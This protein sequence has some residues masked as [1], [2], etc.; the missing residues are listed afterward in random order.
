[1]FLR[2]DTGTATS[3]YAMVPKI[4]RQRN[5]FTISEKHVTT[6]A[7]DKLYPINWKFI[8]PGDTLSVRHQI[9]A[10]LTTQVSDL[11]DDLY[12]DLHAWYVPMRL[13]QTD[14]ARY[15]FNAQPGG[16]QQDNSALTSPKI[17]LTTL[18]VP[19][20][21]HLQFAP[22]STYDYFG[23]PT[24]TIQSSNTDIV[25]NEHINNYLGRAYNF[26]W[27]SDYR[28][29]N[30]Q[31]P[32]TVDLDNGPDNYNDY[33]TV[34]PRGKRHDL[35]TSTLPFLQ[36]GNPVGAP[37]TGTAPVTGIGKVNGNFVVGSQTNI[38]DSRGTLN[39]Y[40][41]S[42]N[43]DGSSGDN[44]YAVQGT[45]VSNGY[46]QIFADMTAGLSYMLINNLRLSVAVQQLLEA[47]ARGGTRD[48]E[49]INHRWGVQVPD[50]R[51]QRPEYLGGQTF[52]FDGNVVPST[53]GYNDGTDDIP[54]GHLTAFSQSM[55]SMNITH[56]FVEHGIFMILLSLRSNLTYQQALWRELSH[57]T[58][59]D[60]YQ[61]EFSNIGE[62]ALLG[63]EIEFTNINVDNN[64]AF[65][66]QEYGYWLR[67]GMNRVTSEMRSS[68]AQSKDY[69]HMAEDFG[70]V[71]PSL[72]AGFIQS[73]TPID[74]NIIVSSALADPVEINSLLSGSMARTLPMY[75]V[76]G[77]TR[78]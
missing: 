47:D 75:S 22:K 76:P 29:E 55:N 17:D 49:A 38:R 70:G 54:Q 4:S 78:I 14:W 74:R 20:A 34:L 18:S 63:K 50:F 72:N 69:K 73:S 2:T 30:L 45:A 1:M 26:I 9:M 65:G 16:F 37:I 60:W 66:Y 33:K 36:K 15:Q 25:N 11:F 19:S 59:L 43:I 44:A 21:G 7:F 61:P 40:N 13:I 6:L 71:R 67:Y 23:Y 39:T 77:M 10:R 42:S 31:D 8:Y 58:R 12:F 41:P 5:Q 3:H 46:P 64:T 27:N 32:V 53:A 57:K 24:N 35:W 48:V 56:S 52:S 62:Q 51:I 28:D 68:Y